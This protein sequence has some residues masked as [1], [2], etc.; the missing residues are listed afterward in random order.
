MRY[1]IRAMGLG[2]ILDAGFRL[3][4]D[5]F[6]LLAGIAALA[7]APIALVSIVVESNPGGVWTTRVL[8]ITILPTFL[9][10]VLAQP[11]VAAAS[12]F[13]V[14][15]LYLGRSV[16]IGQSLRTA[17]H[18]MAPLLGT[19]LL[20]WLF[21]LGGCLLLIIPG[22]YMTLAF[23]LVW[24]V[25]IFERVF[26]RAAMRRSRWLMRGNL[27]RGAGVVFISAV[28]GGVLGGVLQM[29]LGLH[30]VSWHASVRLWDRPS[31]LPTAPR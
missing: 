29:G 5:H 7:Y 25:M 31:R 14:G 6:V 21:I 23:L 1:E 11:V 3:L 18:M 28:L 24:Q 26:G 12:T 19:S 4:R 27:L 20:C 17:V 22:I 30:S 9:L 10:L 13:A 8:L 2:E 15:E 16:S